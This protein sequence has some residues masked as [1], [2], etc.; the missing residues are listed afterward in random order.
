MKTIVQVESVD[1]YHEFNLLNDFWKLY[2]HTLVK[3]SRIWK[4]IKTKQKGIMVATLN[5]SLSLF[6]SHSI[7][8]PHFCVPIFLGWY[9][10]EEWNFKQKS[11]NCLR[12]Q[13]KYIETLI[14]NN[15]KKL[16]KII[17]FWIRCYQELKWCSCFDILF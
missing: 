5:F 1:I 7:E 6:I 16:C 4:S 8:D 13:L 2:I 17:A 9:S 12:R 11:L 10:S 15:K 14:V 3:S